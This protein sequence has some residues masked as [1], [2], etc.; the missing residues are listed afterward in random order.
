MP[1]PWVSA[2]REAILEKNREKYE[3]ASESE[4]KKLVQTIKDALRDEPG[5]SLPKKFSGVSTLI[6]PCA[7][8]H[9]CHPGPG[10][11]VQRQ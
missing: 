1:T 2:A 3:A 5:G 11:L 7:I 6:F 4:R 9:S 10:K 8:L